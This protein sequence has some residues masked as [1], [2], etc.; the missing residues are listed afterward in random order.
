MEGQGNPPDLLGIEDDQLLAIQNDLCERLKA[1]DEARE[2]AISKKLHELEQKHKFTN[3]QYLKHFAQVLE[4]IEPTAKDAPARVKP[5]D[6]MLMLPSLFDGEKP[7]KVKT[8]CERFNQYIKFQTKE[9]NIK[10]TTK[11]ALFE[12]TLDKKAL[13]WFQQHKADFKDLTTMKNMF[14]AR[15]NPWGKTK[16]E[17]L[18]LWNNLS[19]DLQ[20]TDID[21]Q[22]DLVLTLGNMLQQDEQVKM[23]NFIET[24]PTIIQTH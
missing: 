10:D 7:E 8:V 23:E 12:H 6:K 13:I 19:F 5:V 17:H 15:Y 1:R 21:E 9:G 11:E 18:Q 14:L 24:V 22:I 3:A 20:K 16:R 4:L 2:R